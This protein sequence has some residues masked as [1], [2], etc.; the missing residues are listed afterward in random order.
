MPTTASSPS[1]ATTIA[2]VRAAVAAARARGARIGFVPTMGA[3]HEG[4]LRLVDEARRRTEFVA[5][6]IFVNPLQFG[7][8]EDL[9]RYPRDLAGDLVAAES[10]GVDLVFAPRA[11]TMYHDVRAVGV[12]PLAL[13]DRWEGA[14]RPGHFAGV[15]TVVAKLF[16]IV[17]PDVAVFGRKDVQQALLVRSMVR[18][19]DFPVEVVVAPIAREP[20][21]LAMSSRNRFL[22]E[23]ER[24]S[25]RALSQALATMVAS[26]AAG[27]RDPE[28]LRQ[29]AVR[30][31]TAEPL[32]TLDYLALVDAERMEEVAQAA[33]G[34]LAIVAARV[35]ATRLIDNTVLGASADQFNG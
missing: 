25:A 28:R 11:G 10:R 31:L 4:H 30:L 14:V 1:V 5:M 9:A 13:H 2:D 17:A 27:E 7:P 19:L 21:G 24:R 35:G 32:V 26:F 29:P 3:L 33:E 16:N 20:D 22:S 8:T 12:L 18:D 34:T 6:S 15:L 23:P